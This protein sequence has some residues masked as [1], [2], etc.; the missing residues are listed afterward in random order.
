MKHYPRWFRGGQGE[1]TTNDELYVRITHQRT[2]RDGALLERCASC[3]ARL[4]PSAYHYRLKCAICIRADEAE[5]P[6]AERRTRGLARAFARADFERRFVVSSSCRRGSGPRGSLRRP[7]FSKQHCT[8]CTGIRRSAWSEP[9][10]RRARGERRELPQALRRTGCLSFSPVCSLRWSLL[11]FSRR[12][13]RSLR[14]ITS[15]RVLPV[16]RNFS[17]DVRERMLHS[18]SMTP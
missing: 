8:Y 5:Q 14:A 11:P 18:W 15:F 2:K 10:H 17:S 12:T 6:A 3:T 7:G 16:A 9:V 1:S 13:L 4:L